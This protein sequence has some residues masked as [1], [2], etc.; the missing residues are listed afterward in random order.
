MSGVLQFL[1]SKF[2]FFLSF[3]TSKGIVYLAPLI[4]AEVLTKE[5]FGVLE[6]ALAGLGMVLNSL[7]NFGVQSAYPFFTLKDNNQ[8]LTDAFRLHYVWLLLFFIVCQITYYAFQF[9]LSYF[10]ALNV[11]YVVSNQVYISTQFK[12]D[13]RISQAVILDSG[14]YI[15][16][17][18]FAVLSSFNI[19]NTS[20]QS[21]SW[22]IQGYALFYVFKAVR[23]IFKIDFTTVWYKYFTV[24]KYSFHV[25]LGGLL[26]YFITVSGRIFIEFF[27]KDFELVGIYAFYFRLSAVVVMVYQVINIAFFKKMYQ[28]DPKILDHYFSICFVVLYAISLLAFLL[29]PFVLPNFSDYFVSTIKEHKSMYFLLATQMVF[30]IATALFSNIID[31]EKLASKNNPLFLVLLVVFV[32]VLF[33]LKVNLNLQLFTF[34]HMLVVF[35]AAM[36]QT[37]T[38]YR[39]QILFFKSSLTLL[40]INLLSIIVYFVIL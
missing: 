7:I 5:D 34:I 12:T 35:F 31:R 20:I 30:W 39:K 32:S 3:V 33:L 22:L 37:Y 15:I 8:N 38:L 27:F 17:I 29:T 23:Q 24:I 19:I 14:V 21:V 1:K 9:N 4:L 6:Y 10:I 28:L 2:W 11:A 18:L 26:V 16:L 25:L 36:I 13:E 40:V